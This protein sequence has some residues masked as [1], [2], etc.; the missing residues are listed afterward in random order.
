MSTSK[1]TEKAS[2]EG[3][4]KEGEGFVE[5]YISGIPVRATPEE[6]G[7]TQVFSARLVEDYSY[8]KNQI[9]T[10]P[11]FRVRKCPSDEAKEYPVDIAVFKSAEKSEDNLFMIVECK[12]P[13]EEAGLR[14]LKLYMDMSPAEV[15]A[16]FNGTAHA[17]IRK[18]QLT[19]GGWDYDPIPNIPQR[20]QRI[21]DIGRF[22]RKD[23]KPPHNLKAVFKDIRNH[24]AQLTTGIVR[25]EALAQEVINLL[26]CKIYDELNT[27]QDE[28]VTF[29]CGVKEDV[30]NVKK[31]IVD[32][33]EEKVKRVYDDV[34]SESDRLN[35]DPHSVAYIVGELQN[36]CVSE[37][38]RD[39]IGDAFEVFIGPALKGSEGQFFTPRNV[40]K[41]AVQ[42][43]DPNPDEFLIDPACGTGGFLI[44]AIERVWQ[45]IRLAAQR[46]KLSDAWIKE[47][48][49][50]VATKY[51]RGIDKDSFLAKVTKAYMAIVGD[52]RGGVFCE[53]SLKPTAEWRSAMREKIPIDSFDVLLT[54]PPFGAKIPV[55]G[56]DLLRKYDLGFK[57]KKQFSNNKIDWVWSRTNKIA[58][59]VPPQVLFIERCLHLLKPGGRLA[60]VLPDGVLGGDKI[61]YVAAFIKTQAKVLAL[62]DC[63]VETFAPMVTTK[64]HIVFLAKKSVPDTDS[65]YPVFMAIAR[66][67]GHNRKG[68]PLPDDDF[69]VIAANYERLTVQHKKIA[70]TE[71]GFVVDSKWLEDNLIVRRYLPE[72][73]EALELITHSKEQTESLGMMKS[74]INTGAN[75]GS[76]DYISSN[77]GLPYILVSNITEEGITFSDLKYVK[78]D[79]ATKG[80]TV[81]SGD[82][83]IN[84]CGN[85]AGVAAVV[86]PDLDGA[87]LCGFAFRMVLKKEWDAH[88]VTAFLN[89]SLGRKQMLRIAAGS[90]LD[91]ITKADLQKVRIIIH[92]KNRDEIIKK[93]REAIQL[94]LQSRKR[95]LDVK[96]LLP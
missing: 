96:R 31:R 72:Y 48:S 78:P 45:K 73:I 63:P 89:S 92:S 32:L 86:P 66:K 77:V 30:D 7:A 4:S 81:H 60:I 36:Y 27:G 68:R 57:W 6:V 85:D 82:I 41:A 28:L 2:H 49:A 23:L 54:N 43:L 55:K 95:L 21:K 24:L 58:K 56:E 59:Q 26:F 14:Q 90:V 70:P 25:D 10:R 64:T 69:P 18:T 33:F 20:G 3:E 42:I 91:H 17:Y 74:R 12:E 51:F 61:G 79:V 75:V 8:H 62:I 44:V 46:R 93:M 34:F 47:E 5:D 80:T 35:L 71:L 52:G 13:N 19:G 84:R 53:N 40:I 16:W 50:R 11:Q 15:G 29:R 67:V 37:A 22:K 87:V 83:V 76:S 88:Y 9:Q 39:V 1:K 38:E 65:S 94:R